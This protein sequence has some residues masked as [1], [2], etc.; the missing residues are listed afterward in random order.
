M[1][2]LFFS[3]FAL[4]AAMCGGGNDVSVNE[5]TNAD[6]GTVSKAESAASTEIDDAVNR[7]MIWKGN[8][9]IKVDNV[10]ETTKKVNEI[11]A[12]YGAFVSGMEL[13]NSNYE[14]S[15][16]I[17]LRVES[18]NF[19]QLIEAIKAEGTYVRNVT[20]SSNDVTEK[21]IDVENQVKYSTLTL[22]IYETVIF[23]E[24]PEAYEKSFG[25]KSLQALKNGWNI[26]TT[27][28]LIFINIW[29]L[30]LIASILIWRWKWI[31]SKLG[32]KK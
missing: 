31:K 15:N 11:C 8:L 4:L 26:V 21:F 5:T 30:V 10:D 18:N 20:I 9:E 32:R 25:S 13:N 17:T 23:N 16:R 3:S 12:E 6:Y 27:L 19:T 14:I 29:P 2:A 22:R 1:K 7:K 24:E 28:V